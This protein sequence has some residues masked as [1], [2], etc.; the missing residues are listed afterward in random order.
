MDTKQCKWCKVVKPISEFH[1]HKPA[2]DGLQNRCKQCSSEY[3]RQ[4]N[5]ARK[6]GL[7]VKRAQEIYDEQDGLCAICDEEL[8]GKYAVDHDHACCPG[9]RTCGECLR[10]LLCRSCNQG[11]GH[12]KDSVAALNRAAHY[13]STGNL[14][15]RDARRST[16]SLN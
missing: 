11:L 13:L 2:K 1:A 16:A 5:L 10:G 15:I 12:F 4:Y 6:Y 8:N 9:E 3:M 7:T 14:S